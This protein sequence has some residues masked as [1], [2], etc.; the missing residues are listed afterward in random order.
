MTRQHTREEMQQMVL[1]HLRALADYWA[2]V[3]VERK[4]EGETEAQ[5]RC[6]GVLFSFLVMLDGEA[7]DMPAFHLV[8]EPHP[9]DEAFLRG[10]GEN[11]WPTCPDDVAELSINGDVHLHDLLYAGKR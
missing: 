3:E 10:E 9:D 11:W 2:T 7:G 4:P 5:W 1:D 6:R 8:P